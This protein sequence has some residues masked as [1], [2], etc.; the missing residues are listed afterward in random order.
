MR[1]RIMI[2]VTD[3]DTSVEE[4]LYSSLPPG[5]LIRLL[6]VG[7]TANIGDITDGSNIAKTLGLSTVFMC[8]QPLLTTYQT[9]RTC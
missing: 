8:I 9:R 2:P 4:R 5:S 3:G 6:E 7:I 1:M